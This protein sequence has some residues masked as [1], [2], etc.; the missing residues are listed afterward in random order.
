MVT[1]A[2]WQRWSEADLAPYMDA[3]LEA[4]GPGRLMFGSDWP[5]SLVAVRYARWF[6]LVAGFAARLSAGERDRVL[7]GTAI[8]A[9]RL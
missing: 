4:F 5:V 6:E 8:E 7:G 3:V 1:E 9:Y 2:D